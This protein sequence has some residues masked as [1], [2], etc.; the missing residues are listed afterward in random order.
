MYGDIL[1]KENGRYQ[2]PEAERPA[3]GLGED[4]RNKSQ[5]P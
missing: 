3:Q 5:S 1:S 4:R 2:G